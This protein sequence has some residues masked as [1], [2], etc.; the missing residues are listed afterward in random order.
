MKSFLALLC[1]F[2]IV[3]CSPKK[4]DD[5]TREEVIEEIY[6]M[7][8][9]FNDL[10]AKEGRAV[11]FAH[12]AAEDGSISRGGRL[13]TGKDS[14]HAYYARS[15]T[16]ILTLTWKPTFVDVSDDLSMAYTWGPTFFKGIREN[17][18]QFENTGTFHSI[19]KRQADGSWRYV[20]D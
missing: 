16:Q 7:E 19:W 20:Y 15:T 8:Q 18:E 6:A 3:G 17:G 13:I 14:I 9:A 4:A 1:I 10:L 5:L 2:V 11:A 12:F